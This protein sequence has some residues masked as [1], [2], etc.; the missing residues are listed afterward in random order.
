MGGRKLPPEE[1]DIDAAVRV[2]WGEAGIRQ[3]QVLREPQFGT[4]ALASPSVH[5]FAQC[6]PPNHPQAQTTLKHSELTSCLP[7]PPP[8]YKKHPCI[9]SGGGEGTVTFTFLTLQKSSILSFSACLLVGQGSSI[10]AL[11]CSSYLLHQ[12]HCT[13]P[14]SCRPLSFSQFQ[15]WM[16]SILTRTH[17]TMDGAA[18]HMQHVQLFK[19]ENSCQKK[20]H[21][22]H[23]SQ[24]SC[25]QT[26]C[27]GGS[28]ACSQACS[29]RAHPCD[30]C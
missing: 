19:V 5:I 26:C 2:G 10:C 20:W 25:S 16:L 17:D 14:V 6:H 1:S 12:R 9:V 28:Q 27:Q 13:G 11:L 3:T 8:L 30:P 21:T 18:C 23:V 24:W 22:E 4:T 7:P 15:P 29:W